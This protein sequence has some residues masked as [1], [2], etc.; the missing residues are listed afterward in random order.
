VNGP[1][2]ETPR[3]TLRPPRA[4]DFEGWLELMSDPDSA[5]FIGG[6][7]PPN[8]AWRGLAA[9]A[10]SWAL[11]GFGM[12]SVLERETGRWVG[13][14]GPLH[15]HGWPG[16][17]I[18]WGLVRPAWGRGYALEAATAAMNWTFDHLGWAEVIHVI[19][20]ENAPSR[21][22]ARRLGSGFLRM[23]SLPAP[24][25]GEY[26]LWGQDAAT[27]RARRGGG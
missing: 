10:G 26:E 25:E 22:L 8:G 12:F 6:V 14:V 18:G 27:W 5:R 1:V 2:L 17:E 11:Q 15:P 16:P 21:A 9:T 23:G 24:H 13:R 19:K 7:Q 4:E 20:A 3:L